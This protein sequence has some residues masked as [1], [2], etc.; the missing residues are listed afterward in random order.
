M[1]IAVAVPS[2]VPIRTGNNIR[3]DKHIYHDR[4]IIL[5]SSTLGLGAS[6]F[7]RLWEN[8]NDLETI[9]EYVIGVYW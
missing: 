1:T 8:P 2:N 4:N 7:D 5:R 9:D 3:V 6:L